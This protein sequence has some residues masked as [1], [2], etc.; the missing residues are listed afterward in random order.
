MRERGKT[1]EASAAGEA[2]GLPLLSGGPGVA[3]GRGGEDRRAL[4]RLLLGAEARI[5]AGDGAL[6]AKSSAFVAT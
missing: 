5:R 4:G 1:G 2:S 3:A 6:I